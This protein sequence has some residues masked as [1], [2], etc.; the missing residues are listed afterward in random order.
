M[1]SL[2]EFIWTCWSSC[3]VWGRVALATTTVLGI[4]ATFKCGKSSDVSVLSP[5]C[6]AAGGNED[7]L[8]LWRMMA[9]SRGSCPIL[10]VV[11]QGSVRRCFFFFH[12]VFAFCSSP[13]P[14]RPALPLY[15]HLWLGEGKTFETGINKKTDSERERE[16]QKSERIWCGAPRPPSPHSNILVDGSVTD[17]C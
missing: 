15:L 5:V 3:P 11:I 7:R 12:F 10:S 1:R 14:P 2:H 13:P 9:S 6:F 4:A 17:A 8:A 16:S